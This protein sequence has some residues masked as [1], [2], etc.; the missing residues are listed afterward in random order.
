MQK[1]VIKENTVQSRIKYEKLNTNDAE[2]NILKI[3]KI[4]MDTNIQRSNPG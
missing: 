4:K 2:A 3:L 1:S